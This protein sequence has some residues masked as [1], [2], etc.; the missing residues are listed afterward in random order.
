MSDLINFELLE[1]QMR[2]SKKDEEVIRADERRKFAEWFDVND[3]YV[4]CWWY[5]QDIFKTLDDY[6][7]EL[8]IEEEE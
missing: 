5:L 2:V 1:T 3:R 4:D 6:E 8:K 7:K